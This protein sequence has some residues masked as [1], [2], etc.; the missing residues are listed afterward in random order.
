MTIHSLLTYVEND[1]HFMIELIV[2]LNSFLSFYPGYLPLSSLPLPLSP[3]PSL[4]LPLPL[5][6]SLSPPSLSPPSLPLPT[7]SPVEL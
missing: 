5:P 1:N 7:S 3:S 2:D 6:P 4:S